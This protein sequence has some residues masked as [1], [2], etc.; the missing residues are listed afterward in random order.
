MPTTSRL[1]DEY[2]EKDKLNAQ[3]FCT[4]LSPA[5]YYHNDEDYDDRLEYDDDIDGLQG[6]EDD[7]ESEEEMIHPL[8]RRTSLVGLTAFGPNRSTQSQQLISLPPFSSLREPS[9]NIVDRMQAE[10]ASLRR[11][12]AEAVSLSLRLSE[13]LVNAQAEASRTRSTLRTVESMLEG[14]SKRRREAERTTENEE[15]R[16]RKAEEVLNALLSRSSIYNHP[17]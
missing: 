14:E 8:D 7:Y 4:T 11:Q 17:S 1:P 6:S 3:Q 15:R 10:I 12:S 9:E 13:Q 5:V 2:E 16:R